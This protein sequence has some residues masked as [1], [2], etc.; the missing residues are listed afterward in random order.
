MIHALGREPKARVN[1]CDLQVREL[2]Y[3]P[4]RGYAV[5]QKL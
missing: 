4:C 3:N 2:R 1:V 5:R